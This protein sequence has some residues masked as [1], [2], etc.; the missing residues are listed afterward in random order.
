MNQR[1]EERLIKLTF[2]RGD[3]RTEAML[4][5]VY[6]FGMITDGLVAGGVIRPEERKR[7]HY[8]VVRSGTVYPADDERMLRDTD[9]RSTD[10]LAVELD[11]ENRSE[12]RSHRRAWS[13]IENR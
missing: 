9:I 1:M 3:R 6:E 7:I 2:I 5:E 8:R 12:K 13:R 11:G 4:S 10:C